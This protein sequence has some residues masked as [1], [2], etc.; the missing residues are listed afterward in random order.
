MRSHY[1]VI[2]NGA[3]MVGLALTGLLAKHHFSVAVVEAGSLQFK[4]DDAKTARV[5]TINHSAMALLKY[6]GAWSS[7][8]VD[9]QSTLCAMQVWDDAGSELSFDAQGVGFASLGAVV[10][11]R[12]MVEALFAM[13]Q[14]HVN[15][16]WF[17]GNQ[18][19]ALSRE[20]GAAR[21][22][23]ANNQLLTAD[24]IVGADGAASWVRDQGA[25]AM[26]ERPYYQKA[27]VCVI[28]SS[29]PHQQVAYQKFIN[30]GPIALLPLADPSLTALVWSADSEVSD[31]LLQ[32]DV[33]EFEQALTRMLDYKL[34]KLT[35]ITQRKQFPLIMR[36]VDDYVQA[37]MALVGD[38]AHSIHPLAG[39]GVNLGFMDAAC[40]AQ[41]LI[42]ARA[43][44]K[45]IGE[46]RVLRRYTR[47]R[48]ADNAAMIALM[49]ILQEGFA[50]EHP[51]AGLLR[52][53][54]VNTVNQT[55]WVKNQFV[56][57]AMGL[58]EDLPTFVQV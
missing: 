11:N 23:L 35:V 9:S 36:H 12:A 32:K 56:K 4:Q 52:S 27:I 5:S 54:G 39:Q 13:Y 25:F 15:I 51:L 34:G 28:R 26:T 44:K 49:R 24:L 18:P 46:Q 1:D 45:S 55:Q 40:L 50:I 43:K 10:E 8:P 22:R 2:V 47:W 57:V 48:K 37:Q 16:D 17:L 58:S 29:E 38:A 20:K 19:A 6:L 41:T 3:G 33:V 53:L 30:T 21:V 31:N 14:D 7:I 42:D